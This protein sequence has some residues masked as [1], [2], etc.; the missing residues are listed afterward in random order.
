MDN[1]D[2]RLWT[3]DTNLGDHQW[4]HRVGMEVFQHFLCSDC[5]KVGHYIDASIIDQTVES[6]F[7]YQLVNFLCS[8]LYALLVHNIYHR[9]IMSVVT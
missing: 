9:R 4:G 3:R 2:L 1:R 8:P 6:I 5:L 7:R